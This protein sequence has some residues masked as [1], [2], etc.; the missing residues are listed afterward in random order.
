VT[1]RVTAAEV[2]PPSVA[3]TRVAPALEAV[4]SPALLM[5]AIDGVVDRHETEAV[6]S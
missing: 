6:T 3:V 5:A 1:R 2:T 4:L